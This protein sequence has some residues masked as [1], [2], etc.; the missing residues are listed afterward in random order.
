[1][2]KSDQSVFSLVELSKYNWEK[3]KLPELQSELTEAVKDI[4]EFSE[5][6]KKS[7]QKLVETTQKFKELNDEAK[8]DGIG[9][10]MRRFQKHV[11]KVT[12]GREQLKA[13]FFRCY[14]AVENVRDDPLAV[15]EEVLGEL[16]KL[17]RAELL[18][19]DMDEKVAA[20]EAELRTLKNQDV[21]IRKLEEKIRQ[22]EE[23]THEQ[24]EQ[25][26]QR[27]E[28]EFERI[29]QHLIQD[30]EMKEKVYQEKMDSQEQTILTLKKELDDSQASLFELTQA[31]DWKQNLK[32]SNVEMLE[33]DLERANE[34]IALLSREKE[35]LSKEIEKLLSNTDKEHMVQELKSELAELENVKSRIEQ[36]LETHVM[37]HTNFV[38]THD[39]EVRKFKE[40]IHGLT[41][42][43]RARPS[44][45]EFEEMKKKLAILKGD[46]ENTAFSDTE[47]LLLQKNRKL[48][49]ALNKAKLEQLT[50]ESTVSDQA[51]QLERLKEELDSQTNVLA[52][53]NASKS[54]RATLQ[55]ILEKPESNSAMDL[56]VQ[57]RDRYKLKSKALEQELFVVSQS[58]E[59][60]QKD[61]SSYKADAVS[62]YERIRFLESNPQPYQ[63]SLKNLKRADV[64]NPSLMGKYKKLYT[65][66]NDL[67]NEWRSK[68]K[69]K[70]INQ[71]SI[72]DQIAFFLQSYV[73]SGPRVV[74]L[75]AVVYVFAIH[76]FIF[77]LL[78]G[79]ATSCITDVTDP[80][81]IIV[82]DDP[83]HHHDFDI[84][85]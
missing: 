40:R 57:Q 59:R 77:L 46:H 80:Q 54:P 83:N 14:G 32:D 11:D 81:H 6:I 42:E 17:Q 10:L 45:E 39:L 69:Q 68:E 75:V 67:F 19:A 71:M 5:Q 7:R 66:N 56:I 2:E 43:L 36:D 26:I 74:R 35:E 31:V 15:F 33:T 13:A 78:M 51:S 53:V 12:E 28:D 34:N 79:R 8:I 37:A 73:L 9:K 47:A 25:D 38:E 4:Y 3:I 21:T 41:Q 65:Q 58:I 27:R 52:S 55:N 23:D 16:L 50:L 22:M 62:L 84:V 1:M 82:L 61:V 64:E 85:N 60:L 29:K 24:T 30:F 76:I 44:Q 20:Y 49:S 63:K 48:Q 70:Q 18:L 72:P